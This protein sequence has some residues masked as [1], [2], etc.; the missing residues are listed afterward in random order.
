MSWTRKGGTGNNCPTVEDAQKRS[1]VSTR[2]GQTKDGPQREAQKSAAKAKHSVNS[3]SPNW[4]RPQ[5]QSISSTREGRTEDVHHTKRSLVPVAASSSIVVDVQLDHRRLEKRI[6]Y[7]KYF[8]PQSSMIA[9]IRV[10]M[11]L[12]RSLGHW[13][14][15][16]LLDCRRLEKRTV[17]I[18][19]CP[20][21]KIRFI[22]HH[23]SIINVVPA[24]VHS[25]YI[26]P[27]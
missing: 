24:V 2:E 14:C 13:R 11:L 10:V 25:S 22:P 3:E 17:P 12:R 1:I 19:S 18:G 15:T 8:I 16:S 6:I 9:I 23:R 21:K 27:L 20:T 4:R 5:K 7:R 26:L